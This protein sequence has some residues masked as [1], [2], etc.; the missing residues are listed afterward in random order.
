MRQLL[1]ILCALCALSELAHARPAKWVIKDG[2]FYD[3]GKRVF[4]KIAKP[5]RNYAKFE[6]CEAEIRD[7]PKLQEKHFN[8]IEINCYWHHFDPSGEGENLPTSGLIK[9]INAIHAR[10]MYPCLSVETYGVGGG[11][12][13]AGFWQK[14]PDAIAIDSNGKEVR[15]DEY[16]GLTH[17]PS[18]YSPEYLA[19]SRKY[20]RNLTKVLP[21]EKILWFETTV[22]PQ[23]MGTRSLDFS[24]HACREW[25]KWKANHPDAPVDPQGWPT[26]KEFVENPLWNQFRAEWLADWINDDA[27]AFREV[28]GKDAY[29]AVDYLET[30]GPDMRNR[31]GDSLTFLRHLTAA[32]VIQV[33]WHWNLARRAPN[34]CAY[35]HVKQVMRETKRDWAI[36]EHMTINGTDYAAKEMEPLLRNTIAQGTRL[37]WEFVN[38]R[39]DSRDG[40]CVYEDD[41][42]PKPTMRVV[43]DNWDRWMAEVRATE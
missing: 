24:K 30:C 31:N 19:A 22:E 28:A 9:L 43:D 36:T 11:Q 15:D 21:V 33:N 10:G 12:V 38:A 8:A 13:P 32:N 2:K 41:W 37:G 39:A 4:L 7:L 16:G 1:L 17:V 5:I 23:Y 34:Q 29:I 35:D 3:D 27:A 14:H 26:P 25:G 40:F 18:L 6:E 42:S 20:M